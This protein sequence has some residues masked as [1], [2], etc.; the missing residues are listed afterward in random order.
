MSETKQPTEAT[1]PVASTES[2]VAVKET[3][4][5]M[6][7]GMCAQVACSNKSDKRCGRCK[8]LFYCS[9]W[10]ASKASS[11]LLIVIAQRHCY[12]IPMLSQQQALLTY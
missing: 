2:D 12:R 6:D 7:L 11:P 4:P 10:V 8:V 1:G 5:Q 3:K 9:R